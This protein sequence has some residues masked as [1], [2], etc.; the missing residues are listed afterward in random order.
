VTVGL[1]VL[2]GFVG[3]WV[4]EGPIG[5]ASPARNELGH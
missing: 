3:G 2:A 1:V 5:P 4:F